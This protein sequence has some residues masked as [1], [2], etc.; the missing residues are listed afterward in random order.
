MASGTRTE[1]PAVVIDTAGNTVLN[2]SIQVNLRSGGAATV[3]AAET[4]ATTTANPLTTN[5]QGQVTGWLNRGAYNLVVTGPGITGYTDPYDSVPGVD[6]GIDTAAI[7][8]LGVTTAKLAASAVTAEKI[9]DGANTPEKGLYSATESF[10]TVATSEGTASTTFTDLATVGPTLTINRSVATTWVIIC[11]CTAN[12]TVAT[13]YWYMDYA[14]SGATT[15]AASTATALSQQVPLAS[16]PFHS[17]AVSVVTLN[18]GSNT[19]TA[20]YAAGVAGTANFV[21][22]TL[23][24]IPLGV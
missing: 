9:A 1:V 2:A 23:V 13:A 22:R 4:G 24:A 20:K 8:D 3:Y 17:S 10:A 18:S 21:S 19:I 16:E 14:V 6:L 15:R 7:A 11:S 5:A 12:N